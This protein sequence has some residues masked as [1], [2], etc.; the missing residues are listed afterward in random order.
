MRVDLRDLRSHPRIYPSWALPPVSSLAPSCLSD[1]GEGQRLSALTLPTILVISP[2]IFLRFRGI[3]DNT[4]QRNEHPSWEVAMP[5]LMHT[6]GFSIFTLN[7]FTSVN[8]NDGQVKVWLDRSR[9]YNNSP[10]IWRSVTISPLLVDLSLPLNQDDRYVPL[11]APNRNSLSISL[12]EG[13]R[14]SR[15]RPSSIGFGCPRCGHC[16]GSSRRFLTSIA[17]AASV[18]NRPPTS[19]PVVTICQFALYHV[20]SWV[21]QEVESPLY[22]SLFVAVFLL[23]WS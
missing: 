16:V 18:F 4:P 5:S 1:C 19:Y 23:Y 17:Y 22:V 13:E 11:D 21:R 10:I 6:G 14:Y 3:T 7:Q 9:S 15:A 12:S 8:T 2:S 20:V